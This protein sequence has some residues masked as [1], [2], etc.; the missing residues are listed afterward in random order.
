M[1]QLPQLE[2]PG[3]RLADNLANMPS[4]HEHSLLLLDVPLAL[5][6]SRSVNSPSRTPDWWLVAELQQKVGI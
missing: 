4:A 1:A 3:F 6:W 5:S 2:Q